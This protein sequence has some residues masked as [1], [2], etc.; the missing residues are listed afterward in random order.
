MRSKFYLKSK[1]AAL[2][3]VLHFSIFGASVKSAW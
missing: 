1:L 3:K 2:Q